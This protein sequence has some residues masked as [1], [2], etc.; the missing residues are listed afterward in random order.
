MTFG[1]VGTVQNRRELQKSAWLIFSCLRTVALRDF[2]LREM[3]APGI[4]IDSCLDC[5]T[6]FYLLGIR[7][8][9]PYQTK[10]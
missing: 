2:V 10:L 4:L 3:V 7:T 6:Q 9:D 1:Y 5:L 8:F